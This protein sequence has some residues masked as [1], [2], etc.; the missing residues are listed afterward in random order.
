MPAIPWL[1]TRR[2]APAFDIDLREISCALPSDPEPVRH[3]VLT[4]SLS[5][6]QMIHGGREWLG[7][8]QSATLRV[9]AQRA[10][11]VQIVFEP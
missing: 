9:L 4:S 5:R 3:P 1:P 2:L 8:N 10:G 6:H 11:A 7:R